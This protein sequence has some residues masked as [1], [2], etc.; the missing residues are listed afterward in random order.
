MLVADN[1]P[2]GAPMSTTEL[3]SGAAG[4]AANAA[5]VEL[6][7]EVIVIPVSDVD[8]A[9][10]FYAG[11]D[12]RLDADFADEQGFRI[13]QFTPPGSACSIQFGANVTSAPPGSATNVYLIVSDVQAARDAIAARGVSVSDVF[14]EGALGDRFHSDARVAGRAPDGAT[15]GSFASF[16][17]PDGNTWLLQEI[18]SRLPGRIDVGVT[19]FGSTAEL[20]E[21]LRRAAAAHGEHEARTGEADE[22]WP[23]WYAAYIAAEQAEAELPK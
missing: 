9:K 10:A 15:Y 17:D 18:T 22:N 19:T 8:R 5:D 13:V 3:H 16:S 14:H 1:R 4:S 23:D 6:K 2:Q 7:L 20:A 11:L 21:A 12:W